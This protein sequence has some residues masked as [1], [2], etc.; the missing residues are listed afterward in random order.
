MKK[1]LLFAVFFIGF[2]AQAQDYNFL[3]EAYQSDIDFTRKFADSIAKSYREKQVF[4]DAREGKRNNVY[5][6][7]YLPENV[8]E[9]TKQNIKKDINYAYTG[10]CEECLKVHFKTT[11]VGSNPD[12][13][14][15]GV[16]K[17]MFNMYEGKFL[18]LFP[19]W[20]KYIDPKAVAEQIAEK[21][22]A[23]MR[24]GENKVVFN[25]RRNNSGLWY[26][27]NYSDRENH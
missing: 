19:F 9:A 10:Y 11:M 5:S 22:Y 4:F 12:L 26:I 7:V 23:S 6:I 27:Q 21:G 2:V 16:K 1:L 3:K 14:I 25:F 8:T 17:Y 15:E 13:E 24:N 20:Q 18:D